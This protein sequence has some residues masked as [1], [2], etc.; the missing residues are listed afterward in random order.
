M[1]YRH[2]S[3][4]TFSPMPSLRHCHMRITSFAMRVRQRLMPK[5]HNLGDDLKEVALKVAS[6]PKKNDKRPRTV[7]FTQGSSSTIVACNGTVKEYAVVPLP[8]E[9]LVDTNGAG[10]AFVGG[11]LSQLVQEKPIEECVDA[12]HWA[13]KYIIQQSGT[14]ISKDCD[15][16]K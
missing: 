15:Y 16:K 11:F 2:P 3:L 7:V 12:G 4:S 10:D 6:S 13:A 14:T 9:Q 8:K 1:G 5:K